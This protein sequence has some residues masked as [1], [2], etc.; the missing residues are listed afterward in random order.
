MKLSGGAGRH[1][2]YCTNIHPGES[3]AEVRDNLARYVLPVRERVAP[4]EPF[5]LGLRL[6]G[7]AARE[8]ASAEDQMQDLK[9]FLDAHGLYV[10]TINGFPYGTFHAQAVN[11]GVEIRHHPASS[12]HLR[13]LLPSAPQEP[14]AHLQ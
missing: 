1:L 8:L 13:E 12:A 5:G 11:D 14:G 2:T 3:W 4:G 7:R 6:S 10:F 9:R